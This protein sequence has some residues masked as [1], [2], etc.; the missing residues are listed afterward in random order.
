MSA[1]KPDSPREQELAPSD[2][3]PVVADSKALTPPDSV[4]IEG[5]EN[6]DPTTTI[7]SPKAKIVASTFKK[8]EWATKQATKTYENATKGFDDTLQLTYRAL[9]INPES[10][11]LKD[12]VNKAEELQSKRLENPLVPEES[13]PQAI[14]EH[15][16]ELTTATVMLKKALKDPQL[17]EKAKAVYKESLD[18]FALAVAETVDVGRSN[19]ENDAE[20]E[21]LVKASDLMMSGISPSPDGKDL[22]A[23]LDTIV[24]IGSLTTDIAHT[25]TIVQ[26]DQATKKLDDTLQRTYKA[27]NANASSEKLSESLKHVESWQKARLKNPIV[28]E[29]TP[30]TTLEKKIGKLE[31]LTKGLEEALAPIESKFVERIASPQSYKEAFTAFKE[32]TKRAVDAGIRSEG[33]VKLLEGIEKKLLNDLEHTKPEVLEQKAEALK[34]ATHELEQAILLKKQGESTT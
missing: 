2:N 30:K 29:E 25:P 4:Q 6:R 11:E 33:S 8:A 3:V 9:L 7:S 21:A 17:L 24:T 5:K 26:Y 16:T 13:S 10:K 28:P 20:G 18:N 19:T 14:K 12:V 1:I 23:L 34:A 31:A 15:T 32:A 22:S 27:L